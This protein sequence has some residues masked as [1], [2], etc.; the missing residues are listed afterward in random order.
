MEIVEEQGLKSLVILQAWIIVY[1]EVCSSQ[2][3]VVVPKGLVLLLKGGKGAEGGRDFVGIWRILF[4]QGLP[5]CR[6]AVSD[7]IQ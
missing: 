3:P 1:L 4:T 2:M 7:V 6:V 5:Q